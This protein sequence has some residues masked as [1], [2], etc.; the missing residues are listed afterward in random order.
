MI[1]PAMR[2]IFQLNWFFKS[3]W[4]ANWCTA[5]SLIKFT[6]DETFWLMASSPAE[7]RLQVLVQEAGGLPNVTQDVVSVHEAKS[8]VTKRDIHHPWVPY[9]L[10]TIRLSAHIAAHSKLASSH[11][12]YCQYYRCTSGTCTTENSRGIATAG[13]LLFRTTAL[14][15]E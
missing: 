1:S 3:L 11:T 13:V 15:H 6:T 5:M 8:K 10:P 14:M 9:K 7:L 2:T 4:R 12:P